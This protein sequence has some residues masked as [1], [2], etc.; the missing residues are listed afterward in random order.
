MRRPAKLLSAH[1]SGLSAKGL[2]RLQIDSHPRQG[3]ELWGPLPG[4]EVLVQ[5]G[6]RRNVWL[7]QV[8]QPH[9][10]R[11]EPRCSHCGPC[12][13]C[14]LQHLSDEGQL[15]WKSDRLYRR[16]REVAPEAEL[17]PALASPQSFHYRT[18]VEF[19]FHRQWVG[20]HRRGC[21]DRVVDVDHCW[22]APPAHREALRQTRQWML[23]HQLEGWDPRSFGGDLRYLLLRQAN[24]GDDWLALLVTRCNLP[25]ACLE[26]WRDRLA[27]LG[28]RGLIW[29]EQSSTGGAI[30]PEREHLLLGHNAIE[31]RLGDLTFRLGWRS[32]FQSNPPA[33]R[34][35]LD[36]LKAWLGKPRRLLDLYCGIGSLG[37]Y[38]AD[39]ET[40]LV[41]VENVPQAIEDARRCAQ[42]LG[43]PADFH[44]MA[45]EQ[46]EDWN[47]EVA[48]VDPPR[49]GCHPTLV[50]KLAEHG[51]AQIF[52]VSCN[53]ERFLTEWT[54][55]RNNYRLEKAV[56]CDFFPQ[57]AHIELLAWLRRL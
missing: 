5:L 31:Q 12:G 43:R 1:V 17:L 24:P 40:E 25:V 56:A 39:S 49:G 42:E 48:I 21:F 7:Q 10:Q 28:P 3:L 14:S 29:V 33:Y 41:G 27:G 6:T 20:F 32:F 57:T 22:I 2:A 30:V 55:L 44:A 11:R 18:K 4:E 19:S 37:L 13:G 50:D 9:L 51:P 45:A 16:L 47:A 26:D 34:L 46:W 52:Y 53:P 15:A 8:I 35:L 23:D 38:V 36:Q 54:R